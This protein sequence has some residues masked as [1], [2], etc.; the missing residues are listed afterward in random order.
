MRY[1][2]SKCQ[3]R[4]SGNLQDLT[5]KSVE[6]IYDHYG[7]DMHMSHDQFKRK[8]TRWRHKWLSNEGGIPQTLVKTLD[9]AN[10]EVYPGIY[11]AIKTLLA[12]I[13]CLLYC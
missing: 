1:I 5:G 11:V 10:P 3:V 12:R 7:E 8:V 6:D 9:S 2:Y 13:L 4:I